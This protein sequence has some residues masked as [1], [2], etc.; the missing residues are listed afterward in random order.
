MRSFEYSKADFPSVGTPILQQAGT[1]NAHAVTMAAGLATL[2]ALTP[3]A[4]D[5]LEQVGNEV[6]GILSRLGDEHK[7]P[8]AV[9]GVASMFKFHFSDTPTINSEE[10]AHNSDEKKGRLFDALM[11]DHGVLMPAFHSA[12]CSLPMDRAEISQ[13]EEAVGASLSDMERLGEL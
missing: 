9:T 11:L 2:N 12:F 7:V 8:N 4:Y 10:T 6:R 3:Q 5:H 13:F 1:F